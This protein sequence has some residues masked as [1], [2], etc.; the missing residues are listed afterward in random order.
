MTKISCHLEPSGLY[1][2]DGKRPDDAFMVSWRSGKVLVW[3]TTC[4]DSLGPS[5]ITLAAR[6]ARAVVANA[7]ERKH[8]FPNIHIS[9]V[10]RYFQLGGRTSTGV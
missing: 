7:N 10:E 8:S 2:D 6:E 5:H 9:G 3:D 4:A 1:H